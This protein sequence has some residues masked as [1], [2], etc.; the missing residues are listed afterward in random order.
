[1]LIYKVNFILRVRG[2]LE[3][4]VPWYV[5]PNLSITLKEGGFFAEKNIL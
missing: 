3:G 1:M 5:T 4:T 2:Y